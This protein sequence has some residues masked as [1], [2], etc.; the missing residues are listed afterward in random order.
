MVERLALLDRETSPRRNPFANNNRVA[1][2]RK[3]LPAQTSP[4]WPNAAFQLARELL[5][6]GRT[7]E[8][9]TALEQV[10]EW[11]SGQP[12]GQSANFFTRLQTTVAMAYLRLGE[13]EN[14][15]EGHN[16]EACLLPI[17]EGGRHRLERGSRSALLRFQNLLAENP[18]DLETRWLLNLAAMTLGAY[19]E[20]VP[21]QWLIPPEVFESDFPLPRFYDVAPQLGLD[22]VGTAGGSVLEDFDGD[23]YLDLLVSSWGLKDQIRYFRNNG[24][25]GFTERTHQAGLTGL[26]GGLNMIQADYDNDG[27]IDVLVLR[28]AWRASE[29][30]HPNSLLRNRADGIFEDVTESAGLLTF[31]P[32]QTASWGDFNNDGL[33]DLFVGNESLGTSRH[34]CR[35]YQ[36]SGDGTFKDV[37][38]AHGIAAGGFVKGVVWGD[39]DNDGW[40]DLYISRLLEPNLLFHNQPGKDGRRYFVEIAEKAGVSKPTHGFTTWFWDFDNDG[41]LDLFVSGY[42][43]DYLAISPKSVAADYL[44]QPT[45]TEKP[46]LYRNKTDGKFQD[47]T[48]DMALDRVLFTM[49]AN[50]GDLDNDGFLDFYLGTGGPDFRTLIPNLMFRN[51]GGKGFQDVTTAGGFGHLQKGHGISFGDLDQDGDQ[52]IYAV[53]GGAYEGDIYPNALF[54]NP[55]NE[56]HWLSLVL[57]GTTANRCAIGARIKIHLETP[58]GR[59]TI[60]S[61]VSSGG[62]FGASPLRREIGLA[63][64][65][66]ITALEITWPGTTKPQTWNRL[67]IDRS[68][69]I[70]QDHPVPIPLTLKPLNLSLEVDHGYNAPNPNHRHQLSPN[71]N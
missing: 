67:L 19:P 7:Q 15:L 2:F 71:E 6:S 55:G 5:L 57:Q 17:S 45:D 33:L 59:R 46:R 61:T 38:A 14:C 31:H 25:G 53:M 44:G 41:Y 69:K 36:N 13:Q 43:S 56:N 63:N 37:T 49:G 12:H 50:F 10:E 42:G 47:V 18:E 16:A 1:Y 52:D 34:P 8:A 60:F 22:I 62:S 4:Q 3:L 68:Y 65:T 21:P 58:T 27:R 66:R 64:A 9:I 35:L 28:G 51:D 39:I 20:E 30:R 24:D 54:E 32:T 23:G 40:L 11:L 26:T 29:G 70:L 48:K